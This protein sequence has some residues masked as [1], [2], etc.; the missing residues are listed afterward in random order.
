MREQDKRNQVS[1]VQYKRRA[2]SQPPSLGSISA[3]EVLIQ[4][5]EMQLS[6]TGL[7]NK[8]DLFRLLEIGTD[9]HRLFRTQTLSL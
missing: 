9:S 7:A 5:Y 3:D 2:Y 6:Q 1:T 8:F 4:S